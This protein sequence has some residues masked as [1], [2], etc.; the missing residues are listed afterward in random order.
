MFRYVD[1]ESSDKNALV[2]L[3]LS[4]DPVAIDVTQYDSAEKVRNKILRIK[5]NKVFPGPLFS[6]R[7]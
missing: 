3:S 1:L 5:Q 2:S 7:G 4:D 6:C